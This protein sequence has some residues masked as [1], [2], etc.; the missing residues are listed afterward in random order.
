M[1]PYTTRALGPSADYNARPS[2]MHY[3]DV[4]GADAGFSTVYNTGAGYDV[5]NGTQEAD[6]ATIASRSSAASMANPTPAAN[7]MQTAGAGALLLLLGAIYLEGR[8][9]R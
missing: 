6:V 7:W 4:F 3:G 9:L 5:I 8:V 2:P 1:D